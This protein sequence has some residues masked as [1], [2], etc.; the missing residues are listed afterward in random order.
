MKHN[1]FLTL[2]VLIASFSCKKPAGEGGFASIEGRILIQQYD[3]AFKTKLTEYY[4]SG[5]SV[6]IIYGDDSR[7]SD[8]IRTTNDGYFKF[9]YL[10]KGNYTVFVN[11]KDSTKPGASADKPVVFNVSVTQRKQK[12][13]LSDISI[14]AD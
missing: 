5:E 12:T 8:A 7:V 10:R 13:N 3:P 11:S 1:F 6:Y 14:I 2:C 9:S 4:A